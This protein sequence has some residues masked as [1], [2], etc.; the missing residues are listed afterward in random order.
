MRHG[1]PLAVNQGRKVQFHQAAVDAYGL[2]GHKTRKEPN[3]PMA[4]L[5]V[6]PNCREKTP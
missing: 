2:D 4:E 6:I 3:E 5:N 1:L